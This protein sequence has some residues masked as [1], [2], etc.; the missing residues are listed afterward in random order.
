[1]E[2]DWRVEQTGEDY[3]GH[4]Q[5]RGNVADRRPVI[6]RASDIVGPG[7]DAQAVRLDNFN[8]VLATFNG[9]F[10]AEAGAEN[11]PDPV[12]ELLPDF[13]GYSGHVV[14]DSALGGEQ[15]FTELGTGNVYRRRFLRALYAPESVTWTDWTKHYSVAPTIGQTVFYRATTIPADGEEF[16]L[17]P[18]I[19]GLGL[20]ETYD[21]T[22][23][24][25]GTEVL[26][27]ERGV[28]S[29]SVN[30]FTSTTE[31][32]GAAIQYPFN[33]TTALV[34]VS[35]WQKNLSI[36]FIAVHNTPGTGSITVAASHGE[37]ADR[38]VYWLGISLT[39]ISPA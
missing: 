2:K 18:Q 20:G 30:L 5:K 12:A 28:Y 1:M 16:L 22:Y 8:D 32:F 3:F 10:S 24:S 9:F 11:S 27:L 37:P 6:R 31:D 39:R 4:Q 19:T 21:T 29:G 38:T 7:I 25:M 26:L 15:V 23:G 14:S 34:A 13:I 36:P 35:R 17:A 33:G